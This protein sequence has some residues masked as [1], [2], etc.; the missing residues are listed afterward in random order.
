MS[1]DIPRL[2]DALGIQARRH[3]DELWAPCP[4]PDHTETRPSWSIVNLPYERSNGTHHCF[5][6]HFEGGPV[7]LVRAVVGMSWSGAKQ[8]ITDRG[9]WL[10]GSLPLA[11]EFAVVNRYSSGLRIP[12]GLISGPLDSW[13]AP[14]K[15]YAVSRGLIPSQVER[16]E[17]C[18]AVD[19]DMGGRILFPIKDETTK[20]L[21]WH[22]RTYCNQDKRYKNA[23]SA[24][25]FDPGAVFGM[26][27]WPPVDQ[28][29]GL[30]LVVTE[31][32][33]DSLACERAGAR[34]IAAVGGSEPHARQLLKLGTWGK[35][36]VATDGD[37]AG[38]AMFYYL[39]HALGSRCDVKRVAIPEGSDAAELPVDQLRVLLR[40]ASQGD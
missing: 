19:G 5:G 6:C 26:R 18:Y 14:V 11:V 33:L 23:S 10:Q 17:I 24:D 16:W 37:K 28:R 29:S 25:G 39:R 21:S 32:A 1:A 22:A 3:R 9:L 8:W 36:L 4:H 30:E 15:R 38:D 35:I 31:G 20:W 13:V 7:D 27:W 34:Y 2:L 12:K 40:V